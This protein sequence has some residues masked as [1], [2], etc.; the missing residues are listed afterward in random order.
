MKERWVWLI[1]AM[2]VTLALVAMSGAAVLGRP[3]PHLFNFYAVPAAIFMV[4]ASVAALV[5]YIVRLAM[6]GEPNPTPLILSAV[7]AKLAPDWLFPR[8]VPIFA[9]FVMLGAFSS[10]KTMI[11]AV[12]PFYADGL[13]IELDRSLFGT[14]PWRISHALL[15]W[16]TPAIDYLY[17]MWLVVTLC[18]MVGVGMFGSN[19]AR[20]RFFYGFYAIWIG[21]GVVMAYALSSAGPCFLGLIGHPEAGAFNI[22]MGAAPKAAWA[23]HYLAV[24]YLDGG[25]GFARGITAMPSVHVSVAFF[26]FL[27]ARDGI[28]K[29][30]AALFFLVIFVGSIHLGWH[31]AADG[32]IGMAVTGLFWHEITGKTA[33]VKMPAQPAVQL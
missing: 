23:Q 8:L 4:V 19:E 24:G 30:A 33:P 13:F 20:K 6:R 12:V 18:T 26:L 31:Y 3:A 21:I 5:I 22:P 17:V 2:T 7:K 1:V 32:L 28:A 14:D 15:G 9:T 29:V 25:E 10:L 11:P 16:A 27:F